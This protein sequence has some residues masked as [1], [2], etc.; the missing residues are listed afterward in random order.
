MTEFLMYVYDMLKFNCSSIEDCSVTETKAIL[1]GSIKKAKESYEK[2]NKERGEPV[3]LSKSARKQLAKHEREAIKL[4]MDASLE[5][6]VHIPKVLSVCQDSLSNLFGSGKAM[7]DEMKAYCDTF[8]KEVKE[9]EEANVESKD[10]NIINSNT[11]EHYLRKYYPHIYYVCVHAFFCVHPF[12]FFS[13]VFHCAFFFPLCLL[14]LFFPIEEFKESLRQLVYTEQEYNKQLGAVMSL[15]E[16]LKG[17]AI[18]SSGEATPSLSP[19]LSDM[20]PL[21]PASLPSLKSVKTGDFSELTLGDIRTIFG[22]IDEIKR[23]HDA[24]LKDLVAA[25]KQKEKED[26]Y[27]ISENISRVIATV[28]PKIADTHI[29]YI[30]DLALALS[31]YNTK[32]RGSKLI[33]SILKECGI[34]KVRD[35]LS[36]PAVHV[37]ELHGLLSS[38]ATQTPREYRGRA[39]LGK[40][41][42]ALY[43]TLELLE[44]AKKHSERINTL[45][46]EDLPSKTLIN[47]SRVF[48]CIGEVKLSASKDKPSAHRGFDPKKHYVVQLI[49]FN[50]LAVLYYKPHLKDAM[51]MVKLELHKVFFIPVGLNAKR[52]RFKLV[53]NDPCNGISD[54][55]EFSVSKESSFNEWSKAI[56]DAITARRKTQFYG[57]EVADV[58]ARPEES[59]NRIPGVLKSLFDFI[60]NRGLRTEGVFR[61]SSNKAL[62][63]VLRNKIDAGH[64]VHLVD[65]IMAGSLIKLWFRELPSQLTCDDLYPEWIA[66][67]GDPA[68][69]KECVAK[70]PV[71]NR[72]ILF[73]LISLCSEVEKYSV[74][75]K[76]KVSNLATC[77]AQCLFYKQVAGTSKSMVN[78]SGNNNVVET[79]IANYTTV[80]DDM[81]CEQ[82]SQESVK[83]QDKIIMKAIRRKSCMLWSLKN[84][85]KDNDINGKSEAKSSPQGHSLEDSLAE[86]ASSAPK[87]AGNCD[88]GSSNDDSERS[89]NDKVEKAKAKH[90]IMSVSEDDCDDDDDDD[91]DDD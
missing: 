12:F 44:E 35:A 70:L 82:N 15:Q 75:N 5:S 1:E 7:T 2:V 86:A 53:Y 84:Y 33:K 87:E 57:V 91:D 18:E 67:A 62:E 55:Y 17:Y 24:M 25:T 59:A 31:R 77:L 64:P 54:A 85:I 66:A 4:H 22:N 46:H 90:A 76:M 29:P 73:E 10:S 9:F 20:L 21:L 42:E 27:I 78:T 43:S 28:A 32:F 65:P 11:I 6:M 41:N 40:A 49:L 48:I 14:S 37:V 47:G 3:S 30:E 52:Y 81:L 23:Q 34:R 45:L 83:K 56:Q 74:F 50:D 36:L 38:I 69:L 68:R 51:V 39:K 88:S 72:N 13:F 26:L 89:E 19:Q 79:L 61:L 58:M 60:R 80:F 16:R 71:P 8:L 63:E